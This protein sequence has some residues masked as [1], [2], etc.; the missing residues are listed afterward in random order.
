MRNPIYL[1]Q[2]KR[3][4]DHWI[5]AGLVDADCADDILDSAGQGGAKRSLSVVLA[6]L[7][8]ILLG[9]AAMSF[10]AANFWGI[11]K[12]VQLGMLFGAMWLAYGAGWYLTRIGHGAVGQA[13]VLL[14]VALFGVN[15]MLIAQIYHISA[16]YPDGV[17]MWALGSLLVAILIPSRAVLGAALIIASIWTWLE[18]VEFDVTF[19]WPFLLFVGVSYIATHLMRWR[20]GFH[21]TFLALI[22]WLTLNTVEIADDLGWEIGEVGALYSILWL[23]V[24]CAGA[25]L[26]STSYLYAEALERYGVFLFFVAFF[27]LHII[28]ADD[29]LGGD[30]TWTT[31]MALLAVATF[32]LAG[33]AWTRGQ[34]GLIDVGGT[35]GALVAVIAF[36][37]LLELGG[38]FTEWLYRGLFLIIAVWIL[39]YGTRH[40][41]RFIINMSFVAFGAE[42]IFIYLETFSTLLNQSLFFAVGGVLLI[43][44]SVALDRLRRRVISGTEA[45]VSS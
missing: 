6:M 30:P 20:P 2:L 40:D 38:V 39:G 8:V 10:V 42:A 9:F 31:A 14:G 4:L 18:A 36:P 27:T 41:D 3:D 13:A 32:I 45:E 11:Q 25:L 17:M 34:F 19:H 22:F 43:T 29:F 37:Y 5:K 24:W 28:D 15:I 1:R 21:L 35:L 7:G 44:M 16:H 33:L 26:S 12:I 23:A